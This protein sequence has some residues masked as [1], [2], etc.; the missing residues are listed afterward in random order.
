MEQ[1]APLM[2]CKLS[3]ILDLGIV[4]GAKCSLCE[5]IANGA[6]CCGFNELQIEQNAPFVKIGI[7]K[8]G[9]KCVHLRIVN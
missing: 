9:A 1:S 3:K 5:L 2:N 4:N 8:N 6:K 7:V